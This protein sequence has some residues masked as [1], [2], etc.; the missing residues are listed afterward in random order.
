MKICINKEENEKISE[1][2]EENK[3]NNEEEYE[4]DEYKNKDFTKIKEFIINEFAKKVDNNND[5]DNIMKLIEC[6]EGKHEMKTESGNKN[7]DKAKKILN[8]FL[9][10][11]MKNNLFTKEEF[12]SSNKNLKISLLYK[13]FIDGKIQKYTQANEQKN[14]Q[15]NEQKSDDYYGVIQSRLDEIRNELDGEIKKKTT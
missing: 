11:L 9:K 2:G 14:T 6:L 15:E 1:D 4:E 8:E 3:S 12:F 13:L 5:I 10:K 7:E